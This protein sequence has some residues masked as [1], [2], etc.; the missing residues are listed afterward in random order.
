MV[1]KPVQSY[2]GNILCYLLAKIHMVAKL[3]LILHHFGK[4]YLL[5]KIH[6]VAKQFCLSSSS[7]CRYLLAKIHMVAKQLEW[8]DIK[9]N[10]LSSSKNPYGSKTA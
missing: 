2:I 6:M 1:A 3:S 8:L 7:T 10:Q 5:A 4:R 9:Q